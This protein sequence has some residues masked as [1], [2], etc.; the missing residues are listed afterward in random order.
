MN[1]IKATTIMLMGLTAMLF[2]STTTLMAQDT[3][4]YKRLELGFRLMPTITS[5]EVIN[6]NGGELSGETLL[7]MSA[8]ALIGFSFTKHIAIQGEVMYSSFAHK[9]FDNA[10]E[11]KINLRYVS[12]PLLLSLNTS[13][14]N[15]INLNAVVGPQLGIN[16]GSDLTTSGSNG[17]NEKQPV[18][19]VTKNDFGLAYGAGIDFALNKRHNLRLDLGYRGV[20]GLMDISDN[21]QT[22]A[23]DSYYIL[24]KSRI[25]TQSVYIGISI[26]I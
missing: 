8:R 14:S 18:L 2:M 23:Q 25:N 15:F 12:I 3:E 17:A 10:V 24:P 21:S 19:S 4:S 9:S 13:K 22:V 7:G 6:A 16:V 1:K 26:M 5:L 20:L 11:R